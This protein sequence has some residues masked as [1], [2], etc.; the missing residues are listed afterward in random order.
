MI[1]HLKFSDD[2]LREELPYHLREKIATDFSIF[3]IK[4]PTVIGGEHG[5]IPIATFTDSE[6]TVLFYHTSY[7]NVKKIDTID[8]TENGTV[9]LRYGDDVMVLQIEGDIVKCHNENLEADFDAV[10]GKLLKMTD[11]PREFNWG[12]DL[13][14]DDVGYC[15]TLREHRCELKR[16]GGD[17]CVLTHSPISERCSSFM[18]IERLTGFFRDAAFLPNEATPIESFEAGWLKRKHE[19]GIQFPCVSQ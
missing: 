6:K 10:E 14:G 9:T 15:R 3:S 17:V 19:M 13:L 11:Y 16:L 5:F 7:K 8:E 1:V 2:I 4:I 18:R 12:C